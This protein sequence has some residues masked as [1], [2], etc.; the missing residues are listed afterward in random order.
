MPSKS[1]SDILK[2]IKALRARA[3]DSASTEGEAAM[4]ASK[5]DELLQKH[6][7]NLSELDVRA[8]GVGKVRWD[9]GQETRP[10]EVLAMF[11]IEAGCNVDYWYSGGVIS[12]V[13]APADV[14]TA[15]Y[16]IDLVSAAVK[17][18]W[19]SFQK[20]SDFLDLREQGYTKRKIGF[21][22]RKGVARRLGER[23]ALFAEADESQSEEKGRNA[24]VPV[25]NALIKNWL[26]ENDVRPKTN[27]AF[28]GNAGGYH[29]GRAAASN[30][31]L[32]RGIAAQKN[33]PL[34][35]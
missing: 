29:A 23:I 15:L 33:A 20:T 35:N 22:F 11:G 14:E 3:S 19:N 16:Y 17:N 10:V 28:V 32:G 27:S 30:V 12:V 25:K 21:S 5:A 26:I 8:E 9:S 18:C 4:A 2:K 6:N 13:G 34:L 24:L 7:I 31:G 1:I